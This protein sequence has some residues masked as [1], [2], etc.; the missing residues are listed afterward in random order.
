MIDYGRIFHLSMKESNFVTVDVSSIPATQ[1]ASAPLTSLRF[2]QN[3]L[4]SQVVAN[5]QV[6]SDN[7]QALLKLSEL[8]VS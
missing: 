4:F 8:N 6:R 1:D 3:N 2:N 7:K 5:G